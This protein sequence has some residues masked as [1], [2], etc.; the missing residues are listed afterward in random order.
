MNVAGHDTVDDQPDA[1]NP[2][3]CAPIATAAG[4]DA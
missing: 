4:L 1:E 3:A 2:T